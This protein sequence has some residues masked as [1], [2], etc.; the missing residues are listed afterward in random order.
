MRGTATTATATQGGDMNNRKKLIFEIDGEHLKM[1]DE[2]AKE[3][4]YKT[5][6][7]FIKDILL[8]FILSRKIE[9]AIKAEAGDHE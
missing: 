5:R 9:Q 1:I 4:G 2:A 7:S 6:T 3:G 8:N